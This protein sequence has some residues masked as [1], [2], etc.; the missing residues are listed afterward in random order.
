MIESVNLSVRLRMDFLLEDL[1]QKSLRK[2]ERKPLKQHALD[3]IRRDLVKRLSS[4]Q[5]RRLSAIRQRLRGK[6]AL[7]LAK[8]PVRAV[9][10]PH[11][12]DEQ[13]RFRQDSARWEKKR[14]QGKVRGDYASS[15][16]EKR[17]R[18]YAGKAY[19]P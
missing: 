8:S 4:H 7:D 17:R 16:N 13:E 2:A 9:V 14:K 6:G 5:S 11:Q 1:S 10:P 15:Q 19:Q 3:K 12:R 18:E